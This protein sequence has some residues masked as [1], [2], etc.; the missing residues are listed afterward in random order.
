MS[1]NQ[2]EISLESEAFEEFKSQFDDI[3]Q[4]VLMEMT[5]KGA[6]DARIS[7]AMD[8]HIEQ[9]LSES[10]E[11]IQ[12]P[13]FRH[14]INSNVSIKNSAKG[15]LCGDYALKLDEKT[16][17]YMLVYSNDGQ[18]GLFGDEDGRFVDYPEEDSYEYDPPEAS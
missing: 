12:I 11:V 1:K 17:R 10:G 7:V 2:F 5:L 14:N 15:S 8:V 6:D 16:G 13:T 9:G 3:M 18:L 4:A